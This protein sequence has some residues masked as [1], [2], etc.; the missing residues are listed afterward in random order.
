MAAMRNF[1]SC[2]YRVQ[3]VVGLYQ[4]KPRTW[5]DLSVTCLIRKSEIYEAKEDIQAW[6][7]CKDP[8]LIAG[9]INILNAAI[10]YECGYSGNWSYGALKNDRKQ[11]TVMD[12]LSTKARSHM[13]LNMQL[14]S[15]WNSTASG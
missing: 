8:E 1:W 10:E 5:R 13:K 2:L 6:N 15:W 9:I 12:T 3:Q 7:G 11:R 14:S 4:K